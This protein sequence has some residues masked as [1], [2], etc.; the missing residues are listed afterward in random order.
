MLAGEAALS[1]GV[2]ADH[3]AV[4]AFDAVPDNWIDSVAKNIRMYYLHQSHGS[5]IMQGMTIINA[6]DDKYYPH[7]MAA[8]WWLYPNGLEI[9]D[10][11]DTAWARQIR[12]Y[13]DT[14]RVNCN[15]VSMSWCAGAYTCDSLET[16][17][18]LTAWRHLE[19]DYPYIKFIYQTSRLAKIDWTDDMRQATLRTNEQIRRWCRDN[20]CYLMDYGAIEG[21]R[22]DGSF[23]PMATDSCTT[24][25]EDYCQ[26]PTSDCPPCVPDTFDGIWNRS[27]M[28]P[29]DYCAHAENDAYGGLVCYRKGKAW[30][31]LM[32]RA[33]GW[34]PGQTLCGDANN[35][36]T[37]NVG[38][39]IFLI[40]YIFK[41]GPPPVNP[42][43]ADVN[44]DSDINVG[45]AVYLINFAFRSGT[46]PH[47]Q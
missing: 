24:W 41:A 3:N 4:W 21:H 18:F 42:D 34:N 44:N 17:A 12:R 37:V 16:V 46:P 43:M 39:P 19:E 26:L 11:G 9:G 10:N 35:D 28:G 13:L 22:A 8:E 38:D 23:D 40:S 5:Q 33:A 29:T 27:E 25:C 14:N 7:R 32:A 2:I 15:L 20:N 47:C 45:D 1:Q 6:R 31:W 36:G 30:W